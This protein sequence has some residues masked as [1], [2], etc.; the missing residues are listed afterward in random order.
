[1][2]RYF[3]MFGL[4]WA[5]LGCASM[6]PA[7]PEAPTELAAVPTRSGEAAEVSSETEGSGPSASSP[8]EKKEVGLAAGEKKAPAA[9]PEA[10]S[11]PKKLPEGTKVLHVGDSFAGALGLPL[12]KM[13]EEAGVKSV[14][15]HTD[16]S[17]LTDWAWNGELQKM[18]WKYNPDLLIITLGANELAISEPAQREKTIK[19]IMSV[20]GDRPC[21]WVAIPLWDGK[22]N[23]LMDVIKDN[24]G[25]CVYWDSNRLIDVE[26]MPRISDGIHPTTEARAQWAKVVFNWL[27]EHR[28]P[29]SKEPWTLSP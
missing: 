5:L 15:K 20:V 28:A 16:S 14:L 29:S 25:S 19:K 17:Y 9:G 10:A 18:L 6:A 12:G 1:M 2:K 26:H 13:L 23:G 8:S 7:G 4:N 3:C 24:V 11:P 22:H 27:K 21:L